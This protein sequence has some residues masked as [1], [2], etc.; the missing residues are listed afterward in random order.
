M[1]DEVAVVD[2][3]M[4]FGAMMVWP[5]DRL[6]TFSVFAVSVPPTSR[7][8]VTLAELAVRAPTSAVSALTSVSA[9]FP[10]WMSTFVSVAP[11]LD[12]PPELLLEPP[13]DER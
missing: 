1:N 5:D 4:K 10:L 11:S 13:P 2:A 3:A 6:A 9:A 12:T 7:S 8:F